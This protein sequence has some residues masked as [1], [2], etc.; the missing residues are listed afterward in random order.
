ML[1][2]LYGVNVKLKFSTALNSQFNT[3]CK[4]L[5]TRVVQHFKHTS[6][7]SK[8]FLMSFKEMKITGHEIE[9]VRLG[10]T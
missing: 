9:S 5:N 6:R 2:V 1:T 7:A 10:G 3:N 4:Y 8:L